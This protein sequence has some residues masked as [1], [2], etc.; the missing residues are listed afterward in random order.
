MDREL[1]VKLLR[2]VLAELRARITAAETLADGAGSGFGRGIDRG[3][4][5]RILHPSLQAVINATG[6][7]LHTNLG[8]A[9]LSARSWRR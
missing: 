7:M 3:G 5:G 6:V 8:R 9:P 1:L 2:D 4:G